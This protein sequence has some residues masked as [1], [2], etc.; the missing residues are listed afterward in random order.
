[1]KD[2]GGRFADDNFNVMKCSSNDAAQLQLVREIQVSP[3]D[4]AK[5][6]GSHSCAGT[7]RR[8]EAMDHRKEAI[9]SMRVMR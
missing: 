5:R 4:R 8:G 3:K 9:A 7:S 2:G 6:A 1:M